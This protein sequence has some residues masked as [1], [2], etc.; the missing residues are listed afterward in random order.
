[1][2]INEAIR[3][4]DTYKPNSYPES[5]KV[6][7]LSQ[8]DATVKLQIIDTHE[9]A[10]DVQ[11]TGY[12]SKTP[13]DTQLL[14]PSPFADEIYIKWLE[15]QIDLA[16]AEYGRYSNSITMYNAA[17]SSYSNYYT[18]THLPLQKNSIRYF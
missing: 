5:L 3:K 12:S 8:L 14:I 10:A 15:A 4:V 18:K 13:L 2:T 9:G 17:I 6:S 1:M 7:W 16:N 11:F